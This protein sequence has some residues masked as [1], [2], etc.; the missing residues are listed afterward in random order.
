VSEL[1]D[2]LRARL[3]E[4]EQVAQAATSNPRWSLDEH[5]DGIVWAEGLNVVADRLYPADAMHIAR[6][7]PARVLALTAA[8]RRALEDFHGEAREW[9]VIAA[10][11]EALYGGHPG[12]RQ[13]WRP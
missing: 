7:D 3:G 6:W 8:L 5:D 10:I 11:G 12:Y 13:E 1:L 9:W 4:D 2:F